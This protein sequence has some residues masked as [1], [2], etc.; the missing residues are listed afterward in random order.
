MADCDNNKIPSAALPN[1]NVKTGL[2]ICD[3]KSVFNVN[4][5]LSAVQ[6]YTALNYITNKLVGMDTK[7]F[8]AIP[9]QR[10]KDVMARV[11]CGHPRK[12]SGSVTDGN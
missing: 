1:E 8:R 4:S 5:I 2:Q 7:W 11:R 10:A 12:S 9:Q 3:T 6:T